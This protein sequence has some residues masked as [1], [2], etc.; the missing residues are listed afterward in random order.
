MLAANEQLLRLIALWEQSLGDDIP[1]PRGKLIGDWDS[2]RPGDRVVITY[3]DP[4]KIVKGFILTLPGHSEYGILVNGIVQHEEEGKVS[5]TLLNHVAI[6][7]ET[8]ELETS[9]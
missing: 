9:L 5:W 4:Y 8:I 7:A 2:A 1:F 3:I 6:F